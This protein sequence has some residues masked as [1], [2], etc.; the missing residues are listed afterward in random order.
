MLHKYREENGSVATCNICGNL[1]L[2]TV[3]NHRTAVNYC[4]EIVLGRDPS[5][6]PT[7]RF[8]RF[9]RSYPIKDAHVICKQCQPNALADMIP[10]ISKKVGFN[11]YNGYDRPELKPNMGCWIT[12]TEQIPNGQGFYANI[13]VAP[14]IFGAIIDIIS[15][16]YLVG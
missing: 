9:E 7:I 1:L 10:K 5:V 6:H 15:Q 13:Q 16:Y 14:K 12:I 2:V 8:E 3:G 4:I 11:I